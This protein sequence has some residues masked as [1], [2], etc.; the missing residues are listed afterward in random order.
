MFSDLAGGTGRF[1]ESDKISGNEENSGPTSNVY[2]LRTFSSFHVPG[3][4]G[5]MSSKTR[6]IL[7]TAE[8]LGK[9]TT[10]EYTAWRYVWDYSVLLKEEIS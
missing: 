5:C 6:R 7:R 9:R 2:W 4:A 1:I 3:P 8:V 10:L